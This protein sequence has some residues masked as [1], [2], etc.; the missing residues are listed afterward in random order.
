MTRDV[1]FGAAVWCVLAACYLLFAGQVS[2]QE[3]AAGL[4]ATAPATGFAVLLH[5]ARSRRMR[6]RAPWFRLVGR[7]LAALFPDVVRVGLRLLR[8]L[9]RP[10]DGA[11][12][13]VARQPFRYGDADAGD[14][15]RRGMTTLALSVAPNGYVM[16]VPAGDD[17]VLM[18]RLAPAVPDPDPEWPA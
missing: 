9:W 18:H 8:A 7:P 3:I 2:S 11:A 14:A 1:F 6:L 10:P 16:N 12:G 4:V 15:G 17:A 13:M 5:R